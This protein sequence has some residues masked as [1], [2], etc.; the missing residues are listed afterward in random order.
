MLTYGIERINPCAPVLLV[1]SYV[2][3]KTGGIGADGIDDVARKALQI[4]SLSVVGGWQFGSIK[5]E[6]DAETTGWKHGQK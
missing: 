1:K 5:V 6:T 2:Y 4:I 3:L